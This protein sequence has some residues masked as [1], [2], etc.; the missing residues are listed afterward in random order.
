MKKNAKNI[1]NHDEQIENVEPLKK[2]NARRNV[3][4]TDEEKEEFLTK[5]GVGL[6]GKPI[7][8]PPP[9][10]TT[11][12]KFSSDYLAE[13]LTTKIV[14]RFDPDGD[15][16]TAMIKTSDFIN[17]I[18]LIAELKASKDE[19]EK[20]AVGEQDMDF[21]DFPTVNSSNDFTTSVRVAPS[22]EA[23]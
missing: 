1:P 14:E 7:A 2:P 11:Y 9:L 3:R 23:D 20:S 13:E 5:S 22:E 17:A 19:K 8:T 21:M 18:K 16:K 10:T 6:A 4:L 15:P 12:E